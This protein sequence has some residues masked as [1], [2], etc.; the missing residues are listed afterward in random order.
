[1][2]DRLIVHFVRLLLKNHSEYG[3]NNIGLY[4]S[5]LYYFP[6]PLVVKIFPYEP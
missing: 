1:M 6:N 4:H 5:C 3:N 2:K